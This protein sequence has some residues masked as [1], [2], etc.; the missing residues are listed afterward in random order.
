MKG[1]YGKATHQVSGADDAA[2]D[3]QSAELRV[4]LFA[5]TRNGGPALPASSK[6]R[7]LMRE[8]ACDRKGE[9]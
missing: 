9:K 2:R 4:D 1:T 7:I 8:E 6:K 5:L 3:V